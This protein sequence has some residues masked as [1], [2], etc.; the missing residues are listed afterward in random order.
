[1]NRLLIVDGSNLLFQMF[2]GM[3]ARIV[4]EQGKAIR[5]TLGF[6]GALL[7][8][9]RMT[10]P[11]HVAVLFD[12]EHENPRLALDADYKANR[13]DYSKTPEEET[14]FSQLPDVYAALDYLGMKHTE[15]T[16]CETDDL[17]AG[18]A[19]TY[20]Q[21]EEIVIAS[22]DSDFFQLITDKVSVLRYRG[23]NTVL[24]TP[25][26]IKEKLGI[27]PEQYADFKSL[28]GDTADNI[29]GADKIGPKTAAILLNEFG[30]LDQILAHVEGI[31]KP[32][33]KE[34]IIRNADKLRRNY[35]LIRLD[36]TALL[37][38]ALHE[39]VYNYN[40]ITTNEVLRGI[41]LR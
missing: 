9:I 28:T 38:F 34:S 18:Y 22:F 17:I 8:I 15:T 32:S 31:K 13:I 35:K 21:E 39:L 16:V 25:A 3:P 6:V 10:E 27:A 20:G 33:V 5:G 19:L 23:K 40:G 30:T 37:P 26:Y 2:F 11:T 14:P 24:C 4:N 36:N 12:G 29:K 7:K 41:G 1:M